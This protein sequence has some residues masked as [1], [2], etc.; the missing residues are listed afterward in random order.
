MVI[1][2][3][4]CLY[5]WI[6]D[7]YMKF[8]FDSEKKLWN[9]STSTYILIWLF[10]E[11]NYTIIQN[12]WAS[13]LI[14]LPPWI[15]RRVIYMYILPPGFP[16]TMDKL[17]TDSQKTRPETLFSFILKK[18]YSFHW[19]HCFIQKLKIQ[20]Y[21]IFYSLHM[22]IK[23]VYYFQKQITFQKFFTTIKFT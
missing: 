10:Q 6:I 19:N 22:L 11:K 18:K 23:S 15:S 9:N 17:A 5:N 3:V 7:E 12:E 20:M 13:F 14:P 2:N 4:Q 8:L 21:L 16:R 1:D